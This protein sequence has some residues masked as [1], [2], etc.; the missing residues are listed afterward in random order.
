MKFFDEFIEASEPGY[1]RSRT[2]AISHEDLCKACDKMWQRIEI[3]ET[4]VKEL[5]EQ[6]GKKK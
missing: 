2:I 5:T 1:K 6:A 3:L 4:Q